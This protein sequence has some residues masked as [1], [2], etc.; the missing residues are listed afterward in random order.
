MAGAADRVLVVGP[1][2]VGDMVMAQSLFIFLCKTR[3]GLELDVLAPPWS[4]P[5]LARMPQVRSALTLPFAHGQLDMAGRRRLGTALRPAAYQQAIVLPN[6][7]KS[8]LVPWF[9]R[10]PRRTGWRGEMRYGLLNDLRVLDE[11][12]MPLMVQRFVA[13]AGAR[14]EAAPTDI[15]S[16]RLEVSAQSVASCSQ[17]F[18]LDPGLPILALCP[19]AEFGSAKQWPADYYGALADRYLE[20]GWQVVLFGSAND[21]QACAAITAQ[22]NQHPGCWDLA[23]KTSLAEAVDLLSMA[24]GV[25][26]ND[27]GLMHI[28]SALGRPLVAIYGATSPGFT[29]PLGA[30]AAL[31]VSDIDCSPCFKREC[32][33][34]HHRCMRDTSPDQVSG[35]LDTLLSGGG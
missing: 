7:L 3:P 25:V 11:V 14:D 26:S 24:T 8:A 5:L 21:R 10:I 31:Q 33:L 35:K 4:G 13:L 20:Q 29:P 1:S 28:A 23:G 12:A 18:E 32:P 34:G 2:W 22:V 6:S 19:G 17:K 16:P 9:A 27:S 30:G 15:P